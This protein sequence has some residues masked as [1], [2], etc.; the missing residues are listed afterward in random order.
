MSNNYEDEEQKRPPGVLI[1][2]EYNKP[3]AILEP[4]GPS[5][6]PRIGFGKHLYDDNG[7]MK[8]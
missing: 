3:L 2:D 1:V 5:K 8:T 4:P 7:K 6:K